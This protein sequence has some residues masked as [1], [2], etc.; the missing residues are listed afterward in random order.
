MFRL[1]S[2]SGGARFATCELDDQH[3][4]SVLGDPGECDPEFQKYDKVDTHRGTEWLVFRPNDREKFFPPSVISYNSGERR[5]VKA[6]P[7]N[8]EILHIHLSTASFAWKETSGNGFEK[9]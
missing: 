9:L 7:T 8:D 2:P 4:C 1:T 3:T 6:S 5:N